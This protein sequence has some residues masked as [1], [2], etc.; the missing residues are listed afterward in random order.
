MASVRSEVVRLLDAV[1]MLGGRNY[2]DERPEGETLPNT[3]ILDGISQTPAL[4][5]DR[6]TM[7]WDHQLQIDLWEDAAAAAESTRDAVINALDGVDI[8][9]AF[10]LQVTSANRVYDPDPRLS[11]TVITLGTVRLRAG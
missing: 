8:A 9:G 2:A 10:H 11:H 4:K 1:M 3:S 6:R 5:G 7:A